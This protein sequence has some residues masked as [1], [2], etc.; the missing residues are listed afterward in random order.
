MENK[1]S[2]KIGET[3]ASCT[4]GYWGL[5]PWGQSGQDM[6]L[7]ALRQLVQR[8]REKG[9]IYPLLHIPSWHSAGLVKSY[10]VP[11]TS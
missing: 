2:F 8:S 3:V 4:N 9:S 11:E 1:L 10:I 7:T 5:F 6:K